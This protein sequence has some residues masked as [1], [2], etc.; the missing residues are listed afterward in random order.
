MPAKAWM[1]AIDSINLKGL[2][3]KWNAQPN[4]LRQVPE[5]PVMKSNNDFVKW[6]ILNV[7]GDPDLLFSKKHIDWVSDLNIGANVYQDLA[8]LRSL[9]HESITRKEIFNLMK[10][11]REDHNLLEEYRVGIRQMN[12]LNWLEF[13]HKSGQGK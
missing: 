7:L 2:Q 11:M 1:D 10:K 12:P 8:G 13:A 6:C 5:I 4:L 3:G 9:K